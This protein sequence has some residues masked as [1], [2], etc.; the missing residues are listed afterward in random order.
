M[1]NQAKFWDKFAERYAKSPIADEAAYQKK[2]QITREYFNHDSA[3]LEIGCG[4]GSTA[5]LHAPHVKYIHATDI[6]AKMVAIAQRKLEAEKIDNITFEQ[7]AI[8]ELKID[9]G[10]I[11]VVMAHSI[12]HLVDNRDD[13]IAKTYRLLKP[14]GVLVSSTIC[15][16]D[17]MLRFLK[18]IISLGKFL[19]FLPSVMIFS[20]KALES[21]I[22]NA[23]FE[24]DYRWLPGK[25]KALFIVAKKGPGRTILNI[26]D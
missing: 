5:I 14:G 23:G 7:S 13:V 25:G 1:T 8:N 19:G 10:S 24:I 9:E 11:D 26:N 18:P 16:G 4:T 6:S 21:S 22:T 15:P 3:V 2:L 20:A 17:S 12:L